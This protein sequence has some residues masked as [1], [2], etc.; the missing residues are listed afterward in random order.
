VVQKQM[1]D[2]CDAN[3]KVIVVQKQMMDDCDINLKDT[4]VPVI[5]HLRIWKLPGIHNPHLCP[6]LTS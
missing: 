2:D 6:F 4:V 3:L 5:V 1:M